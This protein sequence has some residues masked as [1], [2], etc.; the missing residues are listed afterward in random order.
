MQKMQNRKAA[1]APGSAEAIGREGTP[2]PTE[3]TPVIGSATPAAAA[4]G[5]V[6]KKKPKKKK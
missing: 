4:T 1:Q 5:G 3:S 6:K 2:V